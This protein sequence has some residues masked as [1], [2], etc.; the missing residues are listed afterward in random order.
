MNEF[1]ATIT[2]LL[3]SGI[4]IVVLVAAKYILDELREKK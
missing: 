2:I 4:L 3:L 1:Q